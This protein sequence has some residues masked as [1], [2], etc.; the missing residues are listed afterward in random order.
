MAEPVQKTAVP[1]NLENIF[2]ERGLSKRERD[3]AELLVN[4][5]LGV[6]ETGIRLCISTATA[7][8]H[9]ASIYRKFNVNKRGEFMAIF[10]NRQQKN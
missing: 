2:L 5:G 4:E 10:V 8:S 7:K 9:I 6:E 3:V 1:V